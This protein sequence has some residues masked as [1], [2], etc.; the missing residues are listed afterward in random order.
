MYRINQFVHNCYKELGRYKNISFDALEI[1]LNV[2]IEHAS[3]RERIFDNQNK[4]KYFIGNFRVKVD[5][6]TNEIYYIGWGEQC[7]SLQKSECMAIK[8]KYVKN[9]LN[10]K[11]NRKVA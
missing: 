3:K 11:G 1:R 10:K 6:D 2:N 8:K 9:G 7:Y 5:H 4:W